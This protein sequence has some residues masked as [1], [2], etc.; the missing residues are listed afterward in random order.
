M[1]EI[2]PG[3]AT[4]PCRIEQDAEGRLWIGSYGTADLACYD[5]QTNTFIR[6]GRM[7]DVDMYNYPLVNEDGTVACLIR[8]TQPHVVL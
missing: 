6:Y 4:F 7:D 1:G 5:P 8:Q 3:K 2:N